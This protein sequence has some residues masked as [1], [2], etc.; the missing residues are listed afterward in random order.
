MLDT[1]KEGDTIWGI[2]TKYIVKPESIIKL[3]GIKNN[4]IRVGQKIVIGVS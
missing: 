4:L 1:A 3:S 2:S